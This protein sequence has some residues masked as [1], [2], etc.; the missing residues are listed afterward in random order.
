MSREVRALAGRPASTL[1]AQAG[2]T[3]AMS[4]L[5]KTSAQ[6]RA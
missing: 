1:L 6:L 2:S 4:D 5:F 3:L